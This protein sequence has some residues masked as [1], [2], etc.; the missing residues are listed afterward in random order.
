MILKLPLVDHLPIRIRIRPSPHAYLGWAGTLY[1]KRW[2][3][4]GVP[5][6]RSGR[7]ARHTGLSRECWAPL[8]SSPLLCSPTGIP[9]TPL[10]PQILMRTP[11]QTAAWFTGSPTIGTMRRLSIAP[12]ANSRWPDWLNAKPSPTRFSESRRTSPHRGRSFSA[13]RASLETSGV[14][15]AERPGR[16]VL[17]VP[18]VTATPCPRTSPACQRSRRTV[19]PARALGIGASCATRRPRSARSRHRRLA[20][21]A[22]RLRPRAR[23]PR[24]AAPLPTTI[25]RPAGLR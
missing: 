20:Q 1:S 21:A 24:R 17:T 9:L 3:G 14:K 12:D 18:T 2:P 22:D 11:V 6:G 8:A 7:D 25:T 5:T 4:F 16:L 13:P 19:P 15:V 10:T 23:R